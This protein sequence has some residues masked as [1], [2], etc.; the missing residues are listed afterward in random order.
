MTTWCIYCQIVICW[1]LQGQMTSRKAPVF[2]DF[3]WTL[4]YVGAYLDIPLSVCQCLVA[5]V[6]PQ[7]TLGDLLG[8][9]RK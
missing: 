5:S 7:M 9:P 6:A 4:L 8:D 2:V 1:P 3:L